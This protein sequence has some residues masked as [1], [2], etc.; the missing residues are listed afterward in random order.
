[1]SPSDRQVAQNLARL[2]AERGMSTTRLAAVLR[3]LGRPIPATGVTRVEKGQR[4]VDAGDLV[5]LAIALDVA[6]N[7]LLLPPLGERQTV[8]LAP[9]IEVSTKAAWS[10]ADGD[11][12]LDERILNKDAVFDLDRLSRFWRENRPHAPQEDGNFMRLLV[13]HPDIFAE[14]RKKA[15]EW[16]AAGVPM[17][18]I[19]GYVLLLKT[20]MLTLAAVRGHRALAGESRRRG[21]QAAESE[22]DE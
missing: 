12:P 16:E 8:A 6:P 22:V 14:V 1:M 18:T 11:D 2:R 17:S 5:A 10:W 13:E 19:A 3:G 15:A 7:A 9:G 20:E 4:R 21:E